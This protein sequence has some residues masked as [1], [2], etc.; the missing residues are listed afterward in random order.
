MRG[1]LR[2]IGR[3]KMYKIA[4]SHRNFSNGNK[5][6]K[7]CH[8]GLSFVFRALQRKT[9]IQILKRNTCRKTKLSTMSFVNFFANNFVKRRCKKCIYISVLRSIMRF[10][11][12]K[13]A[14][15]KTVSMFSR[16]NHHLRILIATNDNF[17][18]C[19]M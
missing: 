11:V 15:V 17:E 4:L 19:Y 8:V 7:T 3:S 16:C 1:I 13:Q 5:L 18:A 10:S 6:K 2:L 14:S 12:N 9:I